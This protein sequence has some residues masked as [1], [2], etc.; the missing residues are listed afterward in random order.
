MTDPAVV[1]TVP[2]TWPVASFTVPVTSV[3]RVGGGAGDLAGRVVG[4][5]GDR[6]VASLVVP[7]TAFTGSVV[8]PVTAFTGSVV[9]PVTATGSRAWC[10]WWCR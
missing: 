9:V 5:A 3:H 7:V 8:V 4:G 10:R 2:V 6:P 1:S